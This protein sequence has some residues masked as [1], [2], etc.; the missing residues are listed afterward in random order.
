[1]YIKCTKTF[2][3]KKNNRLQ[4]QS[5][6]S[7]K[8]NVLYSWILIKIQLNKD[9]TFLKMLYADPEQPGYIPVYVQNS[10]S[11]TGT[12]CATYNKS[13]SVPLTLTCN[14]QPLIGR[15]LRIDKLNHCN[16]STGACYLSLCEVVVV[17]HQ[18]FPVGELHLQNGWITSKVIQCCN[19]ALR[20]TCCCHRLQSV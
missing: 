2:Y 11:E 8:S 16:N 17:G 4:H 18:M 14:N 20:A 1:M 6:L 5:Y 10:T 3:F 15:Y 13:Y 7:Y 19:S 12:W 9:V